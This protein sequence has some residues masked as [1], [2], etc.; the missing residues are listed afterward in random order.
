MDSRSIWALSALLTLVGCKPKPQLPVEGPGTTDAY[1][2]ATQSGDPA[3]IRPLEVCESL[4][5]VAAAEAGVSDPQVDSG[6]LAECERELG[7]EAATRGSDNWNSLAGC[8]LRA[9]SGADIEACDRANP[10]PGDAAPS[11]VTRE[12]IACE[13]MLAIFEVEVSLEMGE[14]PPMTD[15]E[16]T[17]LVDECIAALLEEER[18]NLSPEDYDLLLRCVASAG[19]GEQLRAC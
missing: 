15:A 7:I 18:P 17:E 6:L 11:Q 5:R 3:S 13:N 14:Q 2:E 19:D 12:R 9:S 8:V 1:G 4:M 16:R 10:M